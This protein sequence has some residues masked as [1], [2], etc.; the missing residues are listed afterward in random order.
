[1]SIEFN[2]PEYNPEHW[3]KWK[4]ALEQDRIANQRIDIAKA[5]LQGLLSNPTLMQSSFVDVNNTLDRLVEIAELA[6]TKLLD[7]LNN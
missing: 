2:L 4:E 6:T 5:A 3:E 1:M 7:K